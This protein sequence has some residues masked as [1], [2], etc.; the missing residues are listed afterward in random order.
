MQFSD[1]IEED[2]TM[3]DQTHSLVKAEAT[4]LPG[5]AAYATEPTAAGHHVRMVAPETSSSVPPFASDLV[6]RVSTASSMPTNIWYQ[7][8][9]PAKPSSNAPKAASRPSLLNLLWDFVRVRHITWNRTNIAKYDTALLFRAGFL[10]LFEGTSISIGTVLRALILCGVATWAGF[11]NCDNLVARSGGDEEKWRLCIP[12]SNSEALLLS[13]LVAFLLGMFVQITFQRWWETRKLL[14]VVM[15]K[16]NNLSLL[17]GT[18]IIG[19]DEATDRARKTCVR[20]LNLAHASVYKQA[21][22]SD[23]IGDLL[24][25]KMVTEEEWALLRHIS[26][27]H[28]VIYMWVAELIRDCSRAGHLLFPDTMLPVFQA[29]VSALRTSVDDLMMYITCQ[30]PYSYVHLLTLI[31]KLHLLLIVLYS[32]TLIAVGFSKLS[33]E[34][35][36]MGYLINFANQIIYDGILRFHSE[37]VN[38]FGTDMQDYPRELYIANLESSTRSILGQ[39][40]YPTDEISHHYTNTHVGAPGSHPE[41]HTYVYPKIADASSLKASEPNKSNALSAHERLKSVARGLA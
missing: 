38:P 39:A 18:Y 8:W 9:A 17:I 19:S 35:M 7:D 5:A 20:Y 4:I 12:L 36:F 28:S 34:R 15:G 30:I 25:R 32:S 29:D 11:Y 21:T 23:D 31:T 40:H 24:D 16:A 13:S 41:T 37:L 14:Q 3:A 1:V 27:K 10:H 33:L 22:G 26:T 6:E 2:M